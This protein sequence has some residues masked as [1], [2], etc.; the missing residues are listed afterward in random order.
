[1]SGARQLLFVAICIKERHDLYQC[2]GAGLRRPNEFQLRGRA[3]QANGAAVVA[4][5]P[6]NRL[7]SGFGQARCSSPQ[8]AVSVAAWATLS[9]ANEPLDRSWGPERPMGFAQ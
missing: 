3:N 9:V 5:E 4:I 1:M 8:L 2:G 6:L 7:A